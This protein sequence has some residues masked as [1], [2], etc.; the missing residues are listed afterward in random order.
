MLAQVVGTSPDQQRGPVTVP[1]DP[2][3]PIRISRLIL[4]YA[5]TG[6]VALVVVAV[7]TASVSRATGTQEAIRDAIQ[8]T[9]LTAEVA[10][11]PVL[12]DRILTGDP[13]SLSRLDHVVRGQVLRGSLVRVKIWTAD[14]RI[15]YS[16][17]SRLVGRTFP[18]GEDDLEALRTG[19]ADAEISDLTE[20][21]NQY[22]EPAV[23][24]LEVYQGIATPGGTPLLYE[25]YFRYNGVAAAGRAIWLQ[26][27]PYFLGA[28]LLLELLQLPIALSLAR[29]LRAAQ[30]Q[31]EAMLRRALA[32]TEEERRRIASDL[33]DGVVQDLAG[34]AFSL[35]GMA[36]DRARSRGRDVGDR[37]PGEVEVA[38][39][40]VRAA[41]RS[42]RSLLVEIYPPNLYEEGVESALTDLLAGVERRGLQTSLS[43]DADLSR[44]PVTATQLLFRVAQEAVRNVVAH[45]GASR[46]EIVIRDIDGLTRMDVVDDGRGM[47]GSE[48]PQREGHLG[49]RALAGM[50]ADQGAVVSMRSTLGKGTVLTLEVPHR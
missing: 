18:L 12:D 39:A 24:L 6:L 19:S 7:V 28:L 48:V 10:I 14:G 9:S 8:V 27:A 17:E 42:L 38:A 37:E 16:D 41:V 11:E 49:L 50:A 13:A 33:H 2:T 43:V 15:V 32:A 23:Q 30:A 21:E 26:F 4:G 34:V 44:L 47:D 25:A 20:P 3:R 40:Q 35:G 29:R 36:R 31:R 46:V 22:E 5:M 1:G 45:A